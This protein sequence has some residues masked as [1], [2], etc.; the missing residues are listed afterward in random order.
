MAFITITIRNEAYDRLRKL[1][2]PGDSFSDVIMRQLPDP[3]ETAG[4]VLERL[5]NIRIP[6]ANP[7]LRAAL[8][9]GRGRRSTR[10]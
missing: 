3:C 5:K 10:K 1:K 2:E 4:E 7:K 8:L 6:R 9:A